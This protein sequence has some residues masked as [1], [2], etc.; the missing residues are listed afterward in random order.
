VLD[1]DNTAFRH[2]LDRLHGLRDKRPDTIYSACWA[3]PFFPFHELGGKQ[4]DFEGT[5]AAVR[6]GLL[7]RAFVLNDG[8]YLVP[9][10]R[11]VATARALGTLRADVADVVLFNYLWLTGGGRLELLP[12]TAY[13]HRVDPSSFWM[14]TQDASRER[15]LE[16]FERLERALPC[17]ADYVARLQAGSAI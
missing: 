6:S 5:A 1:S 13:F 2:Y 4:I 10:D 15:V 3:F 8:N 14:R 7:R 9:R 16:I 11:Y 12:A 17:D